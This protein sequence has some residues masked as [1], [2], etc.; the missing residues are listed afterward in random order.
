MWDLVNNQKAHEITMKIY[1]NG[2]IVGAVCHGTVGIAEMKDPDSGKHFVQGRKVTCFT[3]SEEAAV[4]LDKVFLCSASPCLT[5][6]YAL[7][8]FV[9]K[10][11]GC[12]VPPRVEIKGKRSR[13]PMWRELGKF[14]HTR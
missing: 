13:L 8:Q 9:P 4:G 2:G 11:T 1:K 6:S 12:T 7:I 14:H 5:R 3:D 10:T